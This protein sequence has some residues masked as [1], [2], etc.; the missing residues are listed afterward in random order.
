MGVITAI[1]FDRFP[2]QRALLNRR[3]KVCFNYDT[4]KT[5]LGTVIRADRETPGLTIINLDDGRTVLGT[6]CQYQLLPE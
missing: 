6:E 5:V 3:V 2:K 4:S 1:S